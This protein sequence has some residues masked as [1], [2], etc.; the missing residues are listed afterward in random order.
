M[1]Y[2]IFTESPFSTREERSKYAYERFKKYYGKNVLELGGYRGALGKFLNGEYTNIDIDKSANIV[3][4]LDKIDRL[5]F[6][7]KSFGT[8]VATDVLE[9][10][11]QIHL[12]FDE[13]CR[14]AKKNIIISLPNQFNC[15]QSRTSKGFGYLNRHLGLPIEIPSDRH[16]WFFSYVEANEFIKKRGAKNNFKIELCE[17]HIIRPKPLKN[18][19]RFIRCGVDQLLFGK[20]DEEDY[21]N[22]YA[23]VIWWVLERNENRS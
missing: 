16:R 2:R 9:H 3:L 22:C 6:K 18:G 7:D 10:L 19:L 14:C 20:M 1:H 21:I 15:F 4:N 12:I 23:W 11:E 13:M 17:P 8:V 5:P